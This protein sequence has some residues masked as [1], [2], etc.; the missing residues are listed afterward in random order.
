MFLIDRYIF[1]FDFGVWYICWP[2]FFSAKGDVDAETEALAVF[3]SFGSGTDMYGRNGNDDDEGTLG[4]GSSDRGVSSNDI[5]DKET[6]KASGFPTFRIRVTVKGK[7]NEC[8]G[9]EL[10]PRMG[11]GRGVSPWGTCQYIL[12]LRLFGT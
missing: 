5:Y 2:G 7:S 9:R 1:G 4:L 3:R 11:S 8:M 12:Q 6:K 10:R